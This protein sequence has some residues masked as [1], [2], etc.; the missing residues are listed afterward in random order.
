MS[1]PNHLDV[2]Q[3]GR[4]L[5]NDRTGVDRAHAICAF[6]TW[7]L[8]SEP[9]GSWGRFAKGDGTLS[10]DVIGLRV[11]NQSYVDTYDIL[12]DS[13]GRAAPQWGP[14]Q[15]TGKGDLSR[16]RAASPPPDPNPYPDPGPDPEPEPPDPLPP[17]GST[18]ITRAEFDTYTHGVDQE[19]M[20]IRARMKAQDDRIT[21]LEHAPVSTV[22]AVDAV[23]AEVVVDF[24]ETGRA[25]WPAHRHGVDAGVSLKRK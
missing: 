17:D 4:A 10:A 11:A 19:L 5:Y 23:L 25:S 12:E 24:H 13:E 8:R 2:V 18:Y 15:P 20:R 3:R 1:I 6:V 9:E 14:T 22:A 16:W 7:E 21:A